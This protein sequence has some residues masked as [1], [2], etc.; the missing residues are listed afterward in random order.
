MPPRKAKTKKARA[1]ARPETPESAVAPE[2]RPA[3]RRAKK[4]VVILSRKRALYS[5]RRL[6]E[7]I[8]QHGHRPLVLDTLRCSMILAKSQPRMMYRGV[9]IRGV[10]VVIPRIGASITAYGLA[11]VTHFDMMGIPVVNGAQSIA[12]SRDK[13]R[14]LQHLTRA[15]LD[16]PRTVMAHDRS[17]VRKLVEEVG[18]LPLIIKLI[19]GTQGVGVMIAHTLPEVQT[20][21]DTFWDLGQEIVLQEFVAE[22]KGRDVRALVVGERVV[23]AMRRQAQKE[24]EFRSNIH[25][26]GEGQPI[27][28]PPSY[29][30][31]AVT[32]AR[33]IG[34]GIAGVDMLEGNAGPRLME[35]NSSPGFEGLEKATG[36]DIAGFMVEYAL[37]FS[38]GKQVSTVSGR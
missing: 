21:V 20:I 35:I 38:E 5:T 18:G 28:L 14:C 30:E 22:S 25:R 31:A 13:L 26:G 7:A 11:V 34:L 4:T 19:R 33:T 29:V 23:G 2:P 17:N 24:G 37:A 15:G 16:M 3:R 8:K 6:V 10:D 36:Q 9:E 27:R 12:R 1:P 32:A